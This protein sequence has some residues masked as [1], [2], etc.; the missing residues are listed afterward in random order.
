MFV[1]IFV[2]M[3]RAESITHSKMSILIF[4]FDM[5]L[6]NVP[7]WSN[8]NWSHTDLH[9]LKK[10]HVSAQVSSYNIFRN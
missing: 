3:V 9:R 1:H 5:N 2:E 8:S 10:G 6:K 4:S 7:P